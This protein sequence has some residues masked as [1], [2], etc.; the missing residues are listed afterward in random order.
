MQNPEKNKAQWLAVYTKPRNEKKVADRLKSQG[1]E[2]YCPLTTEIRQ[3]SDRKKKVK[4]PLF[5]SYVFLRI[6][7][8]ERMEVL[9]DPGVVQFVFWLGKPA[10]IREDEIKNIRLFLE[11]FP[12]AKAHALSIQ[13]GEKVIIQDGVLRDQKGVV[14]EVR[15]NKAFLILDNL[16]F[17]LSAEVHINNLKSNG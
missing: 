6:S 5:K 8:A 17:Q 16:G 10:V 1:F 4:E 13:K 11:E 2:V 3:W 14:K 12:S 7:E 15:G 9:Q